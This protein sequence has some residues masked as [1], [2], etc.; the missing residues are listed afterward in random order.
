MKIDSN[1]FDKIVDNTIE[2]RDYFMTME[3]EKGSWIQITSSSI[4]LY[5][6]SSLTPEELL[7]EQEIPLPEGVKINAH[8]AK[9][10][11]TLGYDIFKSRNEIIQIID[12][13]VTKVLLSNIESS[14]HITEG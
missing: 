9:K 2:D 14:W 12:L 5:Y 6:P 7:R 1:L 8:E 11:L 13:Y 3:D 4:N 10:Y